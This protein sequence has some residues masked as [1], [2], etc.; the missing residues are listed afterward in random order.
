[1]IILPINLLCNVL[2]WLV[3][4]SFSFMFYQVVDGNDQLQNN[5]FIKNFTR[6]TNSCCALWHLCLNFFLQ[7]VQG[8]G[9]VP[10]L[11]TIM[12]ITQTIKVRIGKVRLKEIQFKKL[13]VLS[14]S[15]RSCL[16]RVFNS[17]LG[18]VAILYTKCMWWLAATYRVENL[19]QGLSCQLKFVHGPIIKES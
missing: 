14:I 7:G 6:L 19:A 15:N 18:R 5:P 17:K 16:G 11:P 3:T 12:K 9:T 8:W 4:L 1:M 10:S 2:Y 13:R